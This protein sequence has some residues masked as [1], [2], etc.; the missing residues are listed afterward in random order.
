M[1]GLFGLFRYK[2]GVPVRRGYRSNQ[3]GKPYVVPC[4]VTGK[5]GSVTV[6]MV[7]APLGAGIVAARVPKK[8]LQFSTVF[9]SFKM[10]A[11]IPEIESSAMAHVRFTDVSDTIPNMQD[12]S[13]PPA[14]NYF[15]FEL[16]DGFGEEN[17]DEEPE[18]DDF[19][20]EHIMVWVQIYK[21]LE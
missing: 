15:L 9:T 10:L 18:G 14:K 6:R 7:P 1:K 5:C 2:E 19:D 4:K 20:V 3:I 8:V 21:H 13:D 16:V 17:Y 12:L 11:H